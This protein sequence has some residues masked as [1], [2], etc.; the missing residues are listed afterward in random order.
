[1]ITLELRQVCQQ[2]D[3][4]PI[5]QYLINYTN[6]AECWVLHYLIA[7]CDIFISFFYIVLILLI[8]II[9]NG[10]HTTLFKMH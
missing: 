8:T 10:F 1:M 7:G 5:T 9:P 6:V 2:H 3:C 4:E